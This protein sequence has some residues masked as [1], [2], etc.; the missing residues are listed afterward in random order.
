MPGDALRPLEAMKG[1]EM[2][3]LHAFAMHDMQHLLDFLLKGSLEETADVP[4]I[5]V[6]FMAVL[7]QHAVCA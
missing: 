1:S 7:L 4:S 5:P 2:L 6:P 3:T